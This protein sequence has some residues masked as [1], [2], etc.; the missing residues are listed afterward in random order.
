MK[1]RDFRRAPHYRITDTVGDGGTVLWDRDDELI[2]TIGPWYDLEAAT[3]DDGTTIR[4]VI[5]A[6]HAEIVGS[7]DVTLS[8]VLGITVEGVWDDEDN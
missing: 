7:G 6:L 1:T 2:D 8:A 4:E 3:D 5:E